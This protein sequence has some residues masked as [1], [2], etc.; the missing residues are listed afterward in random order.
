MAMQ[1]D[2]EIHSH[3]RGD[4]VYHARKHEA[5]T[6]TRLMMPQSCPSIVCETLTKWTHASCRAGVLMIGYGTIHALR[7]LHQHASGCALTI[8]HDAEKHTTH[9]K[10]PDGLQCITRPLQFLKACKVG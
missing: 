7:L 8:A 6:A 1:L 10:Q 4:G 2:E 9:T 3:L 5:S